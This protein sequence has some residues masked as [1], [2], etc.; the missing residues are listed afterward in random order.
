MLNWESSEIWS[1]LALR[2]FCHKICSS[3]SLS[4]PWDFE[5]VTIAKITL[6]V[7]KTFCQCHFSSKWWNLYFFEMRCSFWSQRGLVNIKEF[8]W[9]ASVIKESRVWYMTTQRA[10]EKYHASMTFK[11]SVCLNKHSTQLQYQPLFLGS[12]GTAEGFRRGRYLLFSPAWIISILGFIGY[13]CDYFMA[14]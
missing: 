7:E 13:I 14:L 1:F 9:T 2:L 3:Q 4:E 8:Q 6:W 10:F 5:V 12:Q 11:E